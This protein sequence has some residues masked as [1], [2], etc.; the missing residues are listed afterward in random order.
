MSLQLS[1]HLQGQLTKD[2]MYQ[3][4]FLSVILPKI[5]FLQWYF[6]PVLFCPRYFLFYVFFFS[7]KCFFLQCFCS[8]AF[9]DQ[10]FVFLTAPPLKVLSVRFHRN[11]HQKSSK[12]RNLLTGWHKERG[13]W[14][15]RSQLNKQL[16]DKLIWS[17]NVKNK[18]W[19]DQH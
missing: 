19:R 3:V 11:S 1:S 15:K 8:S 16:S 2:R 9:E 7:P 10:S 4:L 14:K 5:P 17:E 12:C 6:A 18:Y 13:S